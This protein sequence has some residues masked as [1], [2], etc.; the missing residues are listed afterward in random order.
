MISI[1]IIGSGNVAH[2]LINAFLD[3]TENTANQV[4]LKQVWARNS[5]HLSNPK[6]PFVAKIHDYCRFRPC[7][8]KR[9][10]TVAV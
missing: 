9:F 1:T 10:R 2:H 4:V 7:H 8:Y 6:I 3:L 5:S